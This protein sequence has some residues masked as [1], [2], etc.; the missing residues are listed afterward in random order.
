MFVEMEDYVVAIGG[1]AGIPDR[2][3]LLKEVVPNKP[4]QFGVMTHHHGDHILGAQAYADQDITVITSKAHEETVRNSTNKPKMKIKTIKNEHT[5]KDKERTLKLIDIGPTPH[6]KNILAAYLPNEGIMFTADH[7]GLQSP[8]NI[9]A[10]GE[11]TQAF[12]KSLKKNKI[13][14]TKILSAHSSIIATDKDLAKSLELAQN[15]RD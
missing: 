5:F 7:F 8:G 15:N 9:T 13:K 14:A 1:A 6:S 11:N 3:K 2:I 10:A 4:I 12:A